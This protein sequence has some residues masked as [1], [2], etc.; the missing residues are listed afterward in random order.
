V[1]ACWRDGIVSRDEELE[2]NEALRLHVRD[3]N[4]W[5]YPERA[6]EYSPVASLYGDVPLESCAGVPIVNGRGLMIGLLGVASHRPFAD[7]EA[8]RSVLQIVAPRLVVELERRPPAEKP[9]AGENYSALLLEDCQDAITLLSPTGERLYSSPTAATLLGYPRELYAVQS[10]FDTVHPDDA[11]RA[12]KLFGELTN[13][14]G[15]RCSVE[16]RCRHFDG[17]WRWILAHSVNLLDQPEVGAIVCTWR[18]VTQQRAAEAALRAEEA[19]FRGL[20]ANIPGAVYRCELEPGGVLQYLSDGIEAITGYPASD[21]LG[22]ARR[23]FLDLVHPEDQERVVAEVLRTVSTGEPFVVEYRSLHRSG[24]LRWI[25]S[26]G[27]VE[28]AEDGT[29]LWVDGVLFDETE[30]RRRD[31]QLAEQN[32]AL[33][34]AAEGISRLDREGRYVQVN[35][36]YARLMGRSPEDLLGSSWQITVHSDSIPCALAAYEEML[37]EGKAEVE[38]QGVRGDGTPFYKQV[39]V[40]LTREEDGTPDGFFCFAKDISARREAEE[41]L[42]CS[43]ARFRALVERASDVVGILDADGFIRYESPAIEQI[44]GYTAAELDGAYA[45]DLIHP[46]DLPQILPVFERLLGNPGLTLEVNYR[47]RHRDGSWRL[48]A[49]AATS[50]LDQPGVR[51]IVVN[52]RDITE[53]Q[54]AEERVRFQSAV[55]EALKEAT[56]EGVLLVSPAGEVLTCNRRFQELWKL[57]D[58]ALASGK[59]QDALDQAAQL[60]EE[61]ETFQQRIRELMLTQEV[62]QEEIALRDGRVL[63]RYGAPVRGE[64]D[65]LYGRV[66]RFRDITE[67][68]RAQRK[69]LAFQ[70]LGQELNTAETPEAAA[71]VV[72]GVADEL[73]GWDACWLDLFSDEPRSNMTL[74][75]QDIVAGKRVDV[76][77]PPGRSGPSALARE[78][79]A[80]GALL[81]LHEPE[82][83]PAPDAFGCSPFGD[84]KRA[85]ASL[86]CVPIRS[87]ERVIGAVSIQSYTFHAYD[88]ASLATFQALADYCGGA[89]ERTLSEAARQKLEQQLIQAQKMEAVGRLAGGVAHD[90]NNML[91][92]IGGYSELLLMSAPPGHSMNG[93]LEQIR[94]AGD[95]ATR[96]TQQLLAFSRKQI[97]QPQVLNLNDVVL[98][99]DRM[100]RRLIGEDIELVTLGDPTVSRIEADPGQVEQVLLNLAVNARDAMP[101]GGKLTIQTRNLFVDEELAERVPEARPGPYVQLSVRDT[102]CGMDAE[103][104]VRIFEPFFT[105]KALGKGTGLGLSTVY[106]IISQS[107][108]FVQVQSAPNQGTTFY[109]H[110]PAVDHI[111]PLAGAP[112]T[113]LPQGAGSRETVLVVEDETMVRD[114]IRRVLETC[115]YEVLEA[116]EGEEAL[117]TAEAY[118]GPI[119]LLLTDVVMPRMSGRELAEQFRQLRPDTQV[120]FMSGYTDD[121]VLRHGLAGKEASFLQKPFS[122]HVLARTVGELLRP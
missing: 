75:F 105:T 87:G 35:P 20:V 6:S 2:L 54:A 56:E 36:A 97:L 23:S 90:F 81:I 64:D 92:V 63:E 85:S 30:R 80:R 112:E 119:H 28:C 49:T 3:R 66:W 10:T 104:L 79:I 114:L 78:A 122:P 32:L 65:T 13:Q 107:E 22:T 48:L 74:V 120:L 73:L 5:C 106:G 40:V 9:A 76:P 15:H 71:R 41:A 45:F 62:S 25:R 7:P 103:T 60:L 83:L 115:G 69:D 37:R 102:G 91:A 116:M 43:E 50:L 47:V 11:G 4:G 121:A 93:P 29:P 96:L 55:L 18:D 98:G 44:M 89:L 82:S 110:F 58:S 100:L 38:L 117:R 70:R 88:G 109:L 95:R 101:Q 94:K 8:V 39:S 52:A 51:G 108:G 26:R 12:R 21:Y 27:R 99:V 59:D 86:L 53:R 31:E 14:P 24:E 113:A 42:R 34:Y 84:V 46:D 72:L 1:L 67:R 33:A 77:V 57:P 111:S 19:R 61:P 17:T 16:I 68:K 118:P